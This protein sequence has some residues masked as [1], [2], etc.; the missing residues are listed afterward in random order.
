MFHGRL[1]FARSVGLEKF[2]S[3]Y[4]V[5]EYFRKKAVKRTD[6]DKRT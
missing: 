4:T 6:M 1:F 3:P 2:L 5:V